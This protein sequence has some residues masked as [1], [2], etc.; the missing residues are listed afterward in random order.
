MSRS[1]VLGLNPGVEGFNYHDP[2]AVLVDG[3][4]VVGAFEEERF[5]GEKSAP[6]VFPARAV[7]ACAERAAKEGLEVAEIAVG[8]SP[9]RWAERWPV[10]AAKAW[11]CAPMRAVVGGRGAAMPGGPSRS[12][13]RAFAAAARMLLEAA[14]A[15]PAWESDEIAA[16]RLRAWLPA[17]LDTPITFVEHHAAHAASAFWPSGFEEATVVVVD[18]VGEVTTTSVWAGGRD[19]LELVAE[20]LMPNSLGYFYAAVTEYLGFSAWGGEG[21][22]MA[23]APYGHDEPAVRKRLEELCLPT[24]QGFEAGEFTVRCLGSGLA[25]D[26]VRARLEVSAALGRSPRA[27]DEP[28]DDFH[29]SVAH[30]AQSILEASVLA[31]VRTAVAAT[32]RPNLCVAGGVFLNCR[33]NQRLRDSGLV[34]GFYAQPVAKDSGV[35]LG[36]AWARSCAP[37]AELATLATGTEI[38]GEATARSLARYGVPFTQV[39]DPAGTVARLLAD[40]RV[41]FFLDGRAEFGPRALGSR[42]VI[43]DPRSRRMADHVNRAVKSRE[44]WRPFGASILAEQASR[45]LDGPLGSSAPFMIESFPVRPEW[46]DRLAGAIHAADGTTRPHLVDARVQPRYHA[47]ISAFERQSGVPAVLN[48]SLNDRARPIADTV[49]DAIGFFFT[50]AADALICDDILVMKGERVGEP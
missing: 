19:G 38:T 40:G 2:A 12:G 4:R 34:A 41:V 36:A 17:E 3:P 37:S 42:S 11:G 25:L 22:V 1:V 8:Y 14:E 16:L 9:R 31:V 7:A 23:L 48:T 35:A 27:P 20:V 26:R 43:A 30:G 45:V 32:G 39:S 24:D 13:G 33:L 44:L 47:A 18:G 46:R 29:R 49:R 21:K 15:A 6:G 50:S 28:I 5:T 10:E